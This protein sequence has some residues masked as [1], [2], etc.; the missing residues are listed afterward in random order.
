MMSYW[1]QT[2]N[3]TTGADFAWLQ[4]PMSVDWLAL[5]A[6][7]GPQGYGVNRAFQGDTTYGFNTTISASTSNLWN[8]FS[9]Q[10]HQT[11]YTLVDGSGYDTLDLSGFS[12]NQT[13]DLR[14]S[15]PS[16][17]V[18]YSSNIAGLRG[19]LTIATGTIIEAAIGGS[20]ND[21]FI[22]NDA[23]NHV[24]GNAGNDI[25]WDSLGSDV[26]LGGPGLDT[27]HFSE[28]LDQLTYSAAGDFL[29]FSRITG[30]SDIDQVWNDRHSWR[31]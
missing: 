22:G 20:G 17:T 1:S 8:Q 18:P 25:F 24:R 23:A 13:I 7:Y 5:D 21:T 12:Q 19:N 9:Q 10:A 3:P 11:A 14:P 29:L 26:Y 30:S 31:Y 16:A 4:T 15:D 6:I 27:L 28:T 2:Q